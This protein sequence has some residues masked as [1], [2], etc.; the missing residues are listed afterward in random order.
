LDKDIGE[1][2]DKLNDSIS[3]GDFDDAAEEV[4]QRLERTTLGIDA[5]EPIL[6]LMEDN[7]KF[8]FGAPGALTHFVERFHKDGYEQRL[9]ESLQ[10]RPTEHTVFMLSRVIWG[11]RGDTRRY[12]C[13]VLTR[14]LRLPD[15]D[16]GVI[17]SIQSVKNDDC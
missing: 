8:D 16:Q 1:L 10:R 4:V 11:S 13:G 5:I 7:P 9:I 12:Y 6:K 17:A 15:L 2:I 14:L 3:T